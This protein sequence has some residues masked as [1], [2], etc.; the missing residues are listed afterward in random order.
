MSNNMLL[1]FAKKYSFL[2][3]LIH[4]L[5]ASAQININGRVLMEE[6]GL[7]ISG[8]SVYFNNTSLGTSTN[9]AGEFHI[10]SAEGMRNEIIVSCVGYETIVFKPENE[11]TKDKIWV[12]KLKL[13]EKQLTDIL[14]VPDAQ[15]IKWLNIF[16]DNF[17]GIT[18]EAGHST[19]LNISDIYFTQ[20]SDSREFKAMSDTP[21]VIIN[22]ML[23]YKISFELID[24]SYNEQSGFTSF[25]GYTRYEELSNKKKWI[26]NR[27]RC[28]YGSTIHF[29]RS[30]I[31]D[32]LKEEGYSIFLINP[33]HIKEDSSATINK[34]NIFQKNNGSD[35]N[36][37]VA[38]TAG[39]IIQQDRNNMD[40][41]I[42]SF[43]DKLMVQY[44]KDPANKNYLQSRI[45]IQGSLP[46][47]FRSFIHLKVPHLFVD[48]TGIVNNPMD[49]LYSGYWIYEKVANLLPFNYLPN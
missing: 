13:K 8:A 21:L 5:T 6:S 45:L 42:I 12:F 3:I 36:I 25:Y 40:T 9:A 31:T 41:Y 27:R 30:I 22:K 39:N 2:I 4:S 19:I 20:G 46:T 7:P 16:K 26:K 33:M 35:M 28:Y 18:E 1:S 48:K 43:P 37:A 29:Y 32:N 49:I 23:G 10:F 24:F 38:T 34:K 14:I 44:S 11:I 17:L 15:R 47:G